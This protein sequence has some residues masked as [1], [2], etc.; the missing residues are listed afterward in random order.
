MK[1]RRTDQSSCCML[2]QESMKNCFLRSNT[3][4][5]ICLVKKKNLT[6]DQTHRFTDIIEKSPEEKT[7]ALLHSRFG[8]SLDY[9]QS[10][11]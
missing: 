8:C 4:L 5:T 7:F 10:M 9:R 3:L 2:S 11:S 6:I 1:L